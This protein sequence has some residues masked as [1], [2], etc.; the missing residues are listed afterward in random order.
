MFTYN[1]QELIKAAKHDHNDMVA[2]M[3]A[4]NRELGSFFKNQYNKLTDQVIAETNCEL[5][6]IIEAMNTNV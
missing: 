2:A 6:Q 4:G 5:W 3:S 1:Q